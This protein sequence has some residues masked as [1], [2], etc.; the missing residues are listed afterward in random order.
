MQQI[1]KETTLGIWKKAEEIINSRKIARVPWSSGSDWWIVGSRSKDRPHFVSYK[2]N[3]KFV[4]D[5]DC[6][7]KRFARSCAHSVVAAAEK[8]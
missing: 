5:K 7:M 1:P 8:L 4:C 2:G 6:P 3:G